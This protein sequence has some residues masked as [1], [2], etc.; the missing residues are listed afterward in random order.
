MPWVG[1]LSVIVAF[2]VYTHESMSIKDQS[3]EN[4]AGTI[5]GN[6]ESMS[7]NNSLVIL[8]SLCR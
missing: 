4:T 6:P 5:S 2:P 3:T 8:L 1:P 7:I